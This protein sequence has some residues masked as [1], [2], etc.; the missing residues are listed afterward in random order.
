LG[1]FESTLQPSLARGGRFY[2]PASRVARL[3]FY[4]RS[5]SDLNK[6]LDMSFDLQ[7]NPT[8]LSPS[9]L[10]GFQVLCIAL[11]DVLDAL[12][13]LWGNLYSLASRR[14]GPHPPA[15]IILSGQVLSAVTLLA[16]WEFCTVVNS[17]SCVQLSDKS[18][19]TVQ[20]TEGFLAPLTYCSSKPC[21][22]LNM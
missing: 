13:N 3:P 1:L 12:C 10:S 17:A 18:V 2:P 11:H 21:W 19:Y 9:P 7:N 6:M 22:C 15:S 8:T 5:R 4:P 16:A 14:G 20:D